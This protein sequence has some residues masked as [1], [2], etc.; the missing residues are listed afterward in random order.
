MCKVCGKRVYEMEKVIADKGVY[1]KTTCFKCDH[2][3][4]ILR[5]VRV[6]EW[7]VCAGGGVPV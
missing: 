7:C 3:K 1:H 5:C 6:C 4:R 2:C